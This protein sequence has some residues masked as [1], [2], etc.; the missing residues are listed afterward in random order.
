MLYL[1]LQFYYSKKH[2]NKY[3]PEEEIHGMRSRRVPDV[4]PLVP[5]LMKSG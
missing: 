2:T 4:Q 5:S 3:Q 1:Q